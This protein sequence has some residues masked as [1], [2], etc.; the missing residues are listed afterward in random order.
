VT[1]EVPSTVEMLEEN[2]VDDDRSAVLSGLAR[3]KPY[4]FIVC[5]QEADPIWLG[6]HAGGGLGHWH[7]LERLLTF[8]LE[9]LRQGAAQSADAD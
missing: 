4:L 5:D 8:T 6:L 7:D 2:V 1:D 9:K 3:G